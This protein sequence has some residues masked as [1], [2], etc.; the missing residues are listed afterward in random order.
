MHAD[1]CSTRSIAGRLIGPSL[2]TR[3]LMSVVC[4]MTQHLLRRDKNPEYTLSTSKYCIRLIFSNY[5]FNTDASDGGN[6]GINLCHIFVLANRFY[7]FAATELLSFVP[8]VL[9]MVIVR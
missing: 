1:K 7:V 9:A 2:L 4:C 5:V 6:A 8:P 3:L